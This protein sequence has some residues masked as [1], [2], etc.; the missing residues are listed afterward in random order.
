MAIGLAGPA[1]AQTQMGNVHN[2]AAS[3]A[4]TGCHELASPAAGA[5]IDRNEH[6]VWSEGPHAQA[7]RAL[8]TDQAKRIARN[9]GLGAPEQAGYCLDCHSTNVPK[10]L[11]GTHFDLAEGVSCEAC[12]GGSGKWIET[13]TNLD[14]TLQDLEAQGLYPTWD[15]V[16]RAEM[17]LDCHFGA[18]GQ[19]AGHK[20]MGAG[21]PRVSFELDSYTEINAHHTVDADYK[22]R[23]T[24]V[25]GMRTWAIGQGVSIARKMDLL[26][27]SQTGTIGFFPEFV[28]F[29]CRGCHQLMS[30]QRHNLGNGR[31]QPR[32][33]DSHI[34][35]LRIAAEQ[36]D[37][38]LARRI[39]ADLAA[40][41]RAATRGRGPLVGA[42][43]KMRD[44]ANAAVAEIAGH[45]FSGQQ[46]R[47][48]M[49][50][51][52]ADGAGGKFSDY[53]SAE[54]VALALDSTLAAMS[55]QGSI[56]DDAYNRMS[57]A[58]GP[59]FTTVDNDETYSPL[60]FASAMQAFSAAIE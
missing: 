52:A 41:H 9:L 30:Q 38:A 14:Y 17:C 49:R 59:V 40:L 1:G 4:Q 39:D 16:K 51:L 46:M 24:Y 58:L 25:D 26:A 50:Q 27:D 35:M 22:E 2:G 56:D 12:H 32:L 60:K 34:R 33:D 18:K 55:A 29:D 21:H 20:L 10:A 23:K 19:F 44:T 11:Q 48:I 45:E 7:Y 36:A 42:A 6:A 53:A 13:H 43:V 15:P 28:F 47:A 3:C 8:L 5:E 54:Q 37:P 31:G 57:N